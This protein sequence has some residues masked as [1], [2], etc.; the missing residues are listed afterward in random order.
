MDVG[1]EGSF[2]VPERYEGVNGRVGDRDASLKVDLDA[3]A[4]GGPARASEDQAREVPC[5]EC[6][7]ILC[8]ISAKG[9]GG[10]RGQEQ[11]AA[12]QEQRLQAAA[13]PVASEQKLHSPALLLL[14]L[15]RVVLLLL[16]KKKER[17]SQQEWPRGGRGEDR[18]VPPRPLASPQ[19]RAAEPV[20]RQSSRRRRRRRG[21]RRRATWS[22]VA[23]RGSSRVSTEAES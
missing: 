23:V 15:L 16:L 11:S 6:G 17:E 13:R 10:R 2:C 8:F 14:V 7:W 5:N 20:E 22:L 4:V 12:G 9:A 3:R 1:V 18:P 19:A 21:R